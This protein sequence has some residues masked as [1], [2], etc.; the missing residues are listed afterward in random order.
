MSRRQHLAGGGL[1]HQAVGAACITCVLL[2]GVAEQARAATAG[3]VSVRDF[4]TL[5]AGDDWAPAIQAAID[6]VSSANGFERGAT[7]Y[8]PPGIYRVGRTV[9]L[10]RNREHH[11]TRLLGYGAVLVGTKALDAQP[12]D[13]DERKRAFEKANTRESKFALTALPGEL[14]FSGKNVGPAI[15]EL[16]QPSRGASPAP[17]VL[18]PS[19]YEG[20]SLVLEGLTFHREAKTTGVGVKIPA[21]HVP[22]NIT[23]RSVVIHNQNVGIH[24]NHCYQI[25]LESCTLRGNTI[26]IWGRN[27]FNGISISNSSIRRGIHGVIIGPN[28]GTWGS[29]GIYIAGC[30]VESLQGYGILSRGGNQVT[31][32]GNYFEANANHIGVETPYGYTTIDTNFF[33]AVSW[34]NREY[35]R[36]GDTVVSGVA[37]IVVNS[38]NVLA[39]A[40]RY[41]T[42]GDSL[43]IL[44]FGL[45][46]KN[47]F[48]VLPAVAEDA[49]LADGFKAGTADGLGAY[50]Y[51]AVA[52][53]FEMRAFSFRTEQELAQEKQLREQRKSAVAAR[54]R[55]VAEKKLAEAKAKKMTVA[56]RVE[57]QLDIGA[58]RLAAGDYVGARAEYR[59]AFTF[60]KRSHRHIRAAIQTTI[61]DSYMKEKDYAEAIK[62]YTRAREIGPGGWR[63]KH[64][65]ANLTQAR[66]LAAKAA[67][68][69]E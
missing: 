54:E 62:A 39:R 35:N 29:S 66:E 2:L 58:A 47:V 55:A 41:Y 4:S 36:I 3:D 56:E 10:G 57:A 24:V 9:I 69:Q 6:H 45:S 12:L 26:G 40:N 48:D 65:A 34:S 50:V 20:M 17:E 19:T 21:E 52:G 11:G 27:H 61:A 67:A 49:K 51:D 28:E 1:V 25:R 7:V 8:F 43:A 63:I 15:L 33:G 18:R 38:Q 31:I 32:V 16:W 22:K 44:V 13:Y 60:L 64:V 53:K 68:A 42:R 23:F 59:K 30:V 5:T 46:G 14:D 37:H